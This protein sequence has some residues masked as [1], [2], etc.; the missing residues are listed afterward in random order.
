MVH[1]SK[2]L[3]MAKS[4][5]KKIKILFL[6]GDSADYLNTGLLIGLKSLPG[7]ETVEYPVCE[8]LYENNRERLQSDVRGN[9]FT[10]FFLLKPDQ[11]NRFHLAFNQ[12]PKNEFDLIIIGDIHNSFGYL[13]Q[14]L[15]HLN[16]KNTV[17]LDGSDSPALYPYH[18]K[19]WRLPA[20]WFLPRAHTRFMYYKREWTPETILYRWY[21]LAPRL[22]GK[23]LPKPKNLKK[24]SF[25]IPEEKIIPTLPAKTKLFPMHI[26]DE[27]LA[28][29]I[30]D[31]ATRYAFEDEAAYYADLQA[32]RFGITTKRAGWDCLRH[33]EIAANGAVICFKDLDKKPDT[34]APHG[35]VPG[36]N[37]LSYRNSDDLFR[38]IDT[39]SETTYS[40][41][42]AESMRWIRNNTCT[43]RA[44]QLLSERFDLEGLL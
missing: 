21:K 31:S 8:V 9:G 15:P 34:C 30:P 10:L 40:A 25:S 19:Y 6:G 28:A 23:Y 5:E 3:S 43:A 7:V 37:C 12:I 16:N 20:Y 36:I 26:V 44:Q 18:G 32:A 22:L 24:I 1:D 29:R 17:I 35:L 41:M 14:F 39:L 33:Y 11:L 42:Q 13:L 38:Q 2:A 4:A 27:E